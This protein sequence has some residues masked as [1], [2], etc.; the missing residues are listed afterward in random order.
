MRWSFNFNPTGEDQQAALNALLSQLLMSCS[1]GFS[2]T[3]TV[4]QPPDYVSPCS[5]AK[6]SGDASHEVV[7]ICKP[8]VEYIAGLVA[9]DIASVPPDSAHALGAAHSATNITPARATADGAQMRTARVPGVLDAGPFVAPVLT[10]GR[11]GGPL[12]IRGRGFGSAPGM[13]LVPN[14]ARGALA[15]PIVSWSDPAIKATIPPAA[16]S[17]PILLRTSDGTGVPA[18]PIAILHPGKAARLLSRTS[19]SAPSGHPEK[20][21]VTA[22]NAAGRKLAHVVVH[23]FDGSA[24]HTA[25]TGRT[26]TATFVIAGFGSQ[27]LLAYAGAATAPIR[28]TWKPVTARP[29]A[30]I[31]MVTISTRSLDKGRIALLLLVSRPGVVSAT[32]RTIDRQAC[33]HTAKR[34]VG[35]I[36]YAAASVAPSGP[37]ELALTL[38]PTRAGRRALRWVNESV[39]GL[40]Q[41]DVQAAIGSADDDR[42]HDV[43][44]A[45]ISAPQSHPRG[46]RLP[47]RRTLDP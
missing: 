34:C 4:A 42:P 25:Q 40:D 37:G 47:T 16:V 3:C 41:G 31:S 14:R 46:R 29:F 10:A 21:I 1:G 5:G 24:D 36:V 33:R 43:R 45:V 18:G 8:T 27:N 2:D 11:R 30:S 44:A 26:G 28:L 22:S 17:G 39:V 15:A 9:N 20:V 13:V 23:L 38:A 12:V 7:R 6:Y 19:T 32:A 35:R